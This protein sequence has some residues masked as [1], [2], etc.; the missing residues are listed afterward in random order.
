MPLASR[1]GTTKSP[2]EKKSK[3]A[4]KRSTPRSTTA[5]EGESEAAPGAPAAS[6]TSVT[7][8]GN[9]A[10]SSTSEFNESSATA[11]LAIVQKE[12]AD[13]EELHAA[14]MLVQATAVAEARAGLADMSAMQMQQQAALD[15]ARAE[16]R[17]LR[18][19]LQQKDELLRERDEQIEAHSTS[20]TVAV[21]A[22][23]LRGIEMMEKMERNIEERKAREASLI[24]RLRDSLRDAHAQRGWEAKLEAIETEAEERRRQDA[25]QIHTL[26]LALEET[27]HTAEGDN[28]DASHR[29]VHREAL[30]GKVTVAMAPAAGAPIETSAEAAA[31]AGAGEG[32]GDD[33]GG[34]SGLTLEGA[35]E[36]RERVKFELVKARTELMLVQREERQMSEQVTAQ[37][38]RM[39]LHQQ[40]RALLS[41]APRAHGAASRTHGAGAALGRMHARACLQ[42]DDASD[43]AHVARADAAGA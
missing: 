12:L 14:D 5:E 20:L 40:V 30:S 9:I 3:L 34:E 4:S 37:M 24:G 11:A 28:A 43:V 33:A 2:P 29:A 10:S 38:A 8:G 15:S 35:K 1:R 7:D 31:A 32:G 17:H 41:T 22:E 39:Q 25:E 16:I 13:T 26:K 36:E 6:P 23:A 42:L 19:E 27:Q 21:A 18:E